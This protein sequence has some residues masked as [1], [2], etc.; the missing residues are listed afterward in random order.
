MYSC[1]YFHQ[2]MK[3]PSF[4]LVSLLI[5]VPIGLSMLFLYCYFGKTATDSLAKMSDCL[6][7][8]NWQ[9]LS[10]K[11]QKYLI[12]MIQNTQ[13]PIHYHGFG[14]AVLNL[15]IFTTVRKRFDYHYSFMNCTIRQFFQ[16]KIFFFNR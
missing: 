1:Y 11:H 9:D 12:I 4:G 15:E 3:H 13:R 10:L 2:E 6:W 14:I 5:S 7:H 16:R 8:C